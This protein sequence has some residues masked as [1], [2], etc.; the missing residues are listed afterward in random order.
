MSPLSPT[1]LTADQQAILRF[2]ASHP[3]D[4]LI[5]SMALGTGLRLAEHVGLKVGDVFA[6]NGT[7]RVRVR[8]RR[9]I[10]KG[11]RAAHVLLPERL[12]M[13]WKSFWR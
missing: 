12:V 2:T 6:P 9:E 1:T 13:K 10:A 3:R 8:I 7:P 4:H 11:G 5:Y